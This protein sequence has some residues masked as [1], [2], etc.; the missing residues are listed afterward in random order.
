MMSKSEKAISRKGTKTQ[1]KT[2]RQ[3][4]A[5]R[6][7]AFAG[8][9]LLVLVVLVSVGCRRDM[10]DQPKMK[11][12]RGTTFFADGLSRRPTATSKPIDVR[13][14]TAPSGSIGAVSCIQRRWLTIARWE[15]I[16][17]LGRP[18]EPE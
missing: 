4:R 15:T 3:G 12:Y 17:P 5:L 8:K 16:T 9:L 2:A 6:L 14:S 11:P 13:W 18:V 1:R 10:Q 7:C